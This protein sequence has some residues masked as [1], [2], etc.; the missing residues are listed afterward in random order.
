MTSRCWGWRRWPC[1][2]L[3]TAPWARS[4]Y[5]RRL[6]A[7]VV[8]LGMSFIW[9]GIAL[10]VLPTPGGE[11]PDWLGSLMTMKPP[12]GAV[13]HHRPGGHRGRLPH[14]ADVVAVR[15]R[16]ARAWAAT[17]GRWSGRAGRC[18]RAR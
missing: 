7:I 10:I 4:I 14:R 3:P 1:A 13:P 9:L 8:T 5:L 17:P 11:A 15:R 6:P 2:S 12:A 16:A 18:S